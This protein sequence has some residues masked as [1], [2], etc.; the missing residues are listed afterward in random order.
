MSS[1]VSAQQ[2]VDKQSAVPQP[3]VP[4]LLALIERDGEMG[5]MDDYC[6]RISEGENPAD[7][8]NSMG[9]N[10]WAMR[11]WIEADPKRME[12]AA[13]AKRCLA[14]KMAWDA[15]KEADNAEVETVEVSRLKIG[16]KQWM[17]SRL[18]RKEWGKDGGDSSGGGSGKI[19]IVI[20]DVMANSVIEHD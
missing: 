13:L 4:P 8:V 3:A 5:V 20:G 18:N 14:D 10:W 7:I 15:M 19:T 2:S 9:V 12:M 1:L 17:A 6:R 16:T 11:G